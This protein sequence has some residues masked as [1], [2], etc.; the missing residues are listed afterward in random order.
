MQ[1]WQI[2]A[3]CSVSGRNH[4]KETCPA[5]IPPPTTKIEELLTPTFVVD[6]LLGALC[7]KENWCVQVYVCLDIAAKLLASAGH[8]HAR[9]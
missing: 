3:G 4:P 5:M 2:V 9:R 7:D 8:E 1:S 6:Y